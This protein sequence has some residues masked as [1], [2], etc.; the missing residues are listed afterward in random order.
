MH[1]LKLNLSTE[2]TSP[3]SISLSSDQ[4][5]STSLRS[6]SELLMRPLASTS[7]VYDQQQQPHHPNLQRQSS[8]H[9][10]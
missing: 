7:V 3:L 4:S 9:D 6:T 10:N 5:L 1:K 2:Y 8:I